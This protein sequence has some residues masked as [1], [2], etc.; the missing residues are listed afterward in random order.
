MSTLVRT[1]KMLGRERSCWVIGNF[2]TL[3]AFH[4]TKAGYLRVDSSRFTCIRC[5]FSFLDQHTAFSFFILKINSM[6]P[7]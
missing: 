3:N 7:G 4:A 6:K 2:Y 1:A 5:F